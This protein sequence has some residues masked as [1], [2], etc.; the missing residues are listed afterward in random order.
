MSKADRSADDGA[1]G[2]EHRFAAVLPYLLAAALAVLVLIGGLGEG[3]SGVFPSALAVL[4]LASLAFIV[5]AELRAGPAAEDADPPSRRRGGLGFGLLALLFIA[6][7]QARLPFA[8]TA[9]VFLLSA[10][11]LLGERTARTVVF[12][13]VVAAAIAFACS[14]T[15]KTLLQIDLP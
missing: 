1:R 9:L 14:W 5:P 4:V 8:P 6:A 15:F 12:N 2:P 13:A 7:I 10:F 11:T 3:E